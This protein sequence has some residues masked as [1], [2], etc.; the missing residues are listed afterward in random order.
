MIGS[1]ALRFLAISIGTA[2]PMTQTTEAE[3][4]LLK[5][6][7]AGKK[8]LVE[9]GV[10][11]GFTTRVLTENADLDAKIW[12]VDPFFPG[13]MGICWGYQISRYYNA[14]A[15]KAKKLRFVRALSTEV[16]NQVPNEVDFVFID[17]DH[18]LEGITADWAFWSK[19][20]TP[21]G[22]VALHD[23]IVPP[24]N[25]RVANYGS[26]KYYESHIRNDDRFEV[27][28]TADSLAVLRRRAA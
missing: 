9:I 21:G 2:K 10:F 15:L 4:A 20:I 19:R 24:H 3:R 18:S 14:N 7:V 25:P 22:I 27:V 11:E 6:H 12:G 8:N 26:H 1:T 28:E 16:G 5:R 23:S 13:R 17:A